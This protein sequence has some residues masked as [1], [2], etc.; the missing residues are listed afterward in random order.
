MEKIYSFTEVYRSS[1]THAPSSG[2]IQFSSLK[3]SSRLRFPPKMPQLNKS[4]MNSRETSHNNSMTPK[5]MKQKIKHKKFLTIN[6]EE[7]STGGDYFKNTLD[8]PSKEFPNL[9]KKTSNSIKDK[10]KQ[11]L[12][13]S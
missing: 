8:I 2:K 9:S 4:Y 1:K 7:S 5:K 11:Q 12:N 3:Q 10:K 13:S 6:K